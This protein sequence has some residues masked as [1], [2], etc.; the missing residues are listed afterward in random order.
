[1]FVWVRNGVLGVLLVGC[2]AEQS[3]TP[4]EDVHAAESARAT[5]SEEARA[6]RLTGAHMLSKR[7][8]S[9]PRRPSDLPEGAWPRVEHEPDVRELVAHKTGVPTERELV[10]KSVA[11]LR[12]SHPDAATRMGSEKAAVN[13]QRPTSLTASLA[14]HSK[15][16]AA[17]QR[18]LE[19]WRNARASMEKLTP[20]ANEAK[21]IALK[22][23]AMGGTP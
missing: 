2:S 6:Q 10:E 9:A 17:Q 16:I 18:Y 12:A 8:T 23:A 22:Q 11:K 15:L 7:T 5:S 19:A 3:P 20:E 21:R 1:M 13:E 14:D 4:T